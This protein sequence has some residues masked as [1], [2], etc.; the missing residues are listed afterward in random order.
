MAKGNG[1]GAVVNGQWS[2]S[3]V[4]SFLAAMKAA[5][6]CVHILHTTRPIS[7]HTRMTSVSATNAGH[8]DGECHAL[9]FLSLVPLTSASLL[10]L[11][12]PNSF[13]IGT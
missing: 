11:I 1:Q 13:V 9:L 7:T 6:I 5:V 10:S 8:F 3:L 12:L 4:R 2:I